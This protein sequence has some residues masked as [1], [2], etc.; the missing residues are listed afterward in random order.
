MRRVFPELCPAALLI[1]AGDSS[2]RGAPATCSHHGCSQTCLRNASRAVGNQGPEAKLQLLRAPGGSLSAGACPCLWMS[3]SHGAS[4]F[5][6]TAHFPSCLFLLQ[7]P[8]RELHPGHPQESVPWGHRPQEPVSP[9]RDGHERVWGQVR[10]QEASGATGCSLP[11]LSQQCSLC[12]SSPGNWTRTRSAASRTGL[13]VPCGGWRSCK[14]PGAGWSLQPAS[15]TRGEG[16]P[17]CS[18]FT[19]A[20]Q[21]LPHC[22]VS[23]WP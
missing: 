15:P 16:L 4:C 18:P 11:G 9:C 1:R 17:G 3:L 20:L 7:G 12:L 22:A 19:E 13:S 8:E 21:G 23:P 5:A 6:G 2:V 10:W 14:W